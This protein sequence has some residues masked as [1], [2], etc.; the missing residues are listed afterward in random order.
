MKRTGGTQPESAGQWGNN[1][2]ASRSGTQSQPLLLSF[3]LTDPAFPLCASWLSNATQTCHSLGHYGEGGAS[4]S[5]VKTCLF[6]SARVQ[7]EGIYVELLRNGQ[8]QVPIF[9]LFVLHASDSD[10]DVF[11]NSLDGPSVSKVVFFF[12]H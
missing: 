2:V 5:V 1:R 4:H 3:N 10:P 8:P 11:R 7:L 9:I 12:L 6:T